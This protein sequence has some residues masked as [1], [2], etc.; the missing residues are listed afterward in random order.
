[1]TTFEAF[2]LIVLPLAALAFSGV[3]Y[4]WSGRARS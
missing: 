1:M 3:A 2:T 4:W